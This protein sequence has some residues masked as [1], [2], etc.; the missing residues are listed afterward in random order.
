[1]PSAHLR[2]AASSSVAV[3]NSAAGFANLATLAVMTQLPASAATNAPRWAPAPGSRGRLR[4]WDGSR[5]TVHTADGRPDLAAGVRTWTTALQVA[6]VVAA[7]GCLLAAGLVS[8]SGTG[9]GATLSVASL[10]V[11]VVTGVVFAT[12]FWAHTIAGSC[13][14]QDSAL[15]RSPVWL[16][17]GWLIPIVHVVFPYQLLEDLWRGLHNQR[18]I[19]EAKRRARP[20]IRIT[21]DFATIAPRVILAW[22]W[23]WAWASGGSLLVLLAGF[24]MSTVVRTVLLASALMCALLVGVVHVIAQQL[25]EEPHG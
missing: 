2:V 6:L 15:R 21:P 20:G 7:L 1:M 19:E 13:R 18:A 24:G 9:E 14:V 10:A 8:G 3:E 22:A 17:V 16:L 25:G 12:G 23:A 4:Y 5:W 11:T